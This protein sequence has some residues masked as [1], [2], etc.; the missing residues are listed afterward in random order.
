MLYNEQLQKNVRK[1]EW[2]QFTWKRFGRD[3]IIE[4]LFFTFGG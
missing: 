2:V 1:H 4:F 3:E